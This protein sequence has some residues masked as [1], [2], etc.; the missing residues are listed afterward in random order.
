MA[1][2]DGGEIPAT[3]KGAVASPALSWT[4]APMGTQAFAIL[5]HDLDVFSGTSDITHWIIW[6]IPATATS[7]PGGL[8]AGD[9]PDGARQGR[10]IN[11]QNAYF[12]PQPPGG[13]PPHHYLLEIYALNAKLG[14]ASGASR[15]EFQAALA[16]KIIGRGAYY[17]IAKP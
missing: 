7:L 12:G 10:A 6:D 5:F 4:G 11:G 13:H 17:G 2:T 3:F 1:W 14:L 16:G 9:T 8:K 15:D